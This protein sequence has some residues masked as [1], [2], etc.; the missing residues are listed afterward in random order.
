MLWWSAHLMGKTWLSVTDWPSVMLEA[1]S[2]G[3]RIAVTDR[4]GSK[5]ATP[6]F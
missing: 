6:T 5:P 1:H 4:T 3:T 2:G